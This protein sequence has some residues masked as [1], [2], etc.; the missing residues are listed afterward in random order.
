[1]SPGWQVVRQI[2]ANDSTAKLV[3]VA[4][5]GQGPNARIIAA[6][7][8]NG[9]LVVMG[10]YTPA[11]AAAAGEAAPAAPAPEWKQIESLKVRGFGVGQIYAGAYSGDSKSDILAIGDDGFAVIRLGGERISLKQFA[12]WRTDEERRVQHELTSGDINSDGFTDLISLDAGEQMCEIFTF[13]QAHRL[14]YAIGFKVFESKLFASGEPREYQPSEAHIADV[15]G[16]G[17]NDLILLSQDRVL[18]YPQM[19]PPHETTTTAPASAA[20]ASSRAPKRR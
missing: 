6:D 10:R 18:L 2:N 11:V 14:L 4:L 5:L 7:K 17:A 9:R 3:S 1:M 8:E 15:T 19:K 12:A 13:S 20:P 16:D